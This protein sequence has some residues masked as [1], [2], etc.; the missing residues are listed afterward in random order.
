[1]VLDL[2]YGVFEVLC[3]AWHCVCVC[4]QNFNLM[5]SVL[6]WLEAW[7][8]CVTYPHRYLPM[9]LLSF[10]P[11]NSAV[12]R[13]LPLTVGLLCGFW[14]SSYP[15]LD[16]WWSGVVGGVTSW[17]SGL[18]ECVV[19]SQGVFLTT[20]LM[21]SLRDPYRFN[22]LRLL[23]SSTASIVFCNINNFLLVFTW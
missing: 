8:P 2:N 6:T 7:L 12:W 9:H 11:I 10:C 18:T 19:V 3:R 13:P 14:S 4:V 1:M 16:E 21:S 17:M 23:F 22:F 15:D 20:E 5:V